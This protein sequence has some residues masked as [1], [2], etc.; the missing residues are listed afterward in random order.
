MGRL[1][2]TQE[3]KETLSWGRSFN[4]TARKLPDGFTLKTVRL[5][6]HKDLKGYFA[7]SCLSRSLSESRDLVEGASKL[8]FRVRCAL[9]E[10]IKHSILDNLENNRGNSEVLFSSNF[11]GSSKKQG[12]SLRMPLTTCRPTSLCAS[13]CYAHDVLDAA[14]A[15]VVRGAIN[16][17]VASMFESGDRREREQIL[18]RLFPHVKRAVRNAQNELKKLPVGFLRRA[19]IR[20]AHVGEI[21]RFSEFANALATQVKDVSDGSVDCVVYTRLAESAKLDKDLW[22]INFTLDEVSHERRKFVPP[23]ARI[24]YSAFKGKTSTEADVNFLE[25]HRWSHIAP[26]GNGGTLCPATLPDTKN[27]SCDAVMCDRCFRKTTG[28]RKAINKS[29]EA[30]S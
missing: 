25:H 3:R 18:L 29:K 28:I 20:F 27:R 6:F 5:T 2:S 16:G 15:A 8:V 17:V 12:T 26:S 22:I 14:P 24:V 11:F 19:N 7:L 23:S 30:M 4:P 21:C 1:N 10:A 13:A 9:E